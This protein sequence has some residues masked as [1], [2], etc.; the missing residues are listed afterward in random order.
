MIR[1]DP[2]LAIGVPEIDDQ[3]QALFEYAARVEEAVQAG[4]FNYRVEE[5]FNFLS[6]YAGKHFEAEERL[7]RESDYPGLAAQV[8]EH[9]DFQR[10]LASLVPQWES[11]GASASLVIALL[12]F[13]EFWLT[14]HIKFSDQ[15][16]AE[17]LRAHAP[18]M[19]R[20]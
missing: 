15:G 6:T 12:G 7:M 16:I 18:Q 19:V 5:I 1:W 17:H 10:R 20:R 9:R 13:M 2:S 8:L 14:D 4:H 11:E 3:H